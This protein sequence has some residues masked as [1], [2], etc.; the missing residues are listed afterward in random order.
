[1]K[2][3]LGQDTLPTKQRISSIKHNMNGTHGC[4]VDGKLPPSCGVAQ[5][6]EAASA[7]QNGQL[8]L[9]YNLY[10]GKVDSIHRT[11][12]SHKPHLSNLFTQKPVA[13]LVPI[14]ASIRKGE[15]PSMVA[16]QAEA[17][18]SLKAAQDPSA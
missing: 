8:Y 12:P 13:N 9:L 15:D 10:D 2:W 18:K 17:L 1:M 11:H 6:Q 3:V 7:L 4:E 5:C 16:T 14:N